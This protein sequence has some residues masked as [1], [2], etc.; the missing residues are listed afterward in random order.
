MLNIV[1]GIV[2]NFKEVIAMKKLYSQ[3]KSLSL[4]LLCVAGAAHGMEMT[5]PTSQ[6]PITRRIP[7]LKQLCLNYIGQN[8][9]H[10]QINLIDNLANLPTDL[11]IEAL[12]ETHPTYVKQNKDPL[13]ELAQSN[14]LDMN[15]LCTVA[16]CLN[17]IELAYNIAKNGPITNDVAL[18]IIEDFFNNADIKTCLTDFKSI[19]NKAFPK[20]ILDHGNDSRLYQELMNKIAMVIYERSWTINDKV[21]FSAQYFEQNLSIREIANNMINKYFGTKSLDNPYTNDNLIALSSCETILAFPDKLHPLESVCQYFTIYNL[22][23][24]NKITI[25]IP[26]G[27]AYNFCVCDKIAF[28]QDCSYLGALDKDG[29]IYSIKIAPFTFANVSMEKI[30]LIAWFLHLKNTGSFISAYRYEQEKGMFGQEWED[31]ITD[32]ESWP[33]HINETLK[34]KILNFGYT[35]IL[36]RLFDSVSEQFGMTREEMINRVMEQD[37][38]FFIKFCTFIK[39]NSDEITNTDLQKV[40][41]FYNWP[42]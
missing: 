23:T 6:A 40:V 10:E 17:D 1:Q 39:N 20:E 16:A 32:I 22:T 21:I 28:S 7:S 38:E 5:I 31:V 19:Y 3:F 37:A 41:Q 9:Q 33:V 2:I 42:I 36:T 15:V 27:P 4:L 13:I 11:A 18:L 8:P 26:S 14:N 24:K 30:A 12:L 34:M 25:P 35:R 29:K